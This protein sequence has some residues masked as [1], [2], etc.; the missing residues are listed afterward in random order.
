MSYSGKEGYWSVEHLVKEKPR[1]PEEPISWNF[2]ADTKFST[3]NI[4]QIKEGIKLHIHKNHDEIIYFFSG[5]GE[6]HLAG[7]KM[8]IKPGDVAFVPAVV[9]H[10]GEMKSCVLV[11]LY[12]PFFDKDNPDRVFVE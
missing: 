8:K 6:F 7:K 3:L 10:G 4:A 2:I 1:A 5:E 11:S 9:P 12:A